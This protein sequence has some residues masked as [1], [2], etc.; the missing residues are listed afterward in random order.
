MSADLKYEYHVALQRLNYTQ[1][2]IDLLR[3]AAR[4]YPT[5]PQSLTNKQVSKYLGCV[6]SLSKVS[7]LL[8]LAAAV[9]EQVH[10]RC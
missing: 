8:F 4:N 9:F 2:Q 5:I 10:G 6:S 7:L 3:D 1:S